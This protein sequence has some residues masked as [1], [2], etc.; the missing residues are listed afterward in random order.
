MPSVDS[1]VGTVITW[2]GGVTVSTGSPATEMPVYGDAAAE[3]LPEPSRTADG[4]LPERSDRLG[5]N[6]RA[7]ARAHPTARDSQAV[8]G[9]W[10]GAGIRF[11]KRVPP[12]WRVRPV[13]ESMIG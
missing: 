1:G 11:N 10:G 9:M 4:T 5:P 2:A 3:G 7:R 12:G 8:L 6:S 13:Y